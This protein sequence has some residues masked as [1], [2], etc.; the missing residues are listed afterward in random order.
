MTILFAW[1]CRFGLAENVATIRVKGVFV[2]RDGERYLQVTRFILNP[3]KTEGFKIQL[4]GLFRDEQMSEFAKAYGFFSLDFHWISSILA[5]I[6]TQ[7]INDNWRSM[8]RQIIAAAR[9]IWEPL[10]VE[11]ANQVTYNDIPFRALMY[12]GNEQVYKIGQWKIRL[13]VTNQYKYI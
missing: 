4:K 6:I 11:G 9:I 7:F 13:F 3:T 5:S 10:L 8:F 2:E 12:F 1:N